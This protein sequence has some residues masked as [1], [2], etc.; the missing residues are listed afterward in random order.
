VFVYVIPSDA[1]SDEEDLPAE[2]PSAQANARLPGTNGDT[3]RA[4][5]LEAP[6]QQGAAAPDGHDSPK[7]ARVS[8]ARLAQLP[9]GGPL[10]PAR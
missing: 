1:V 9:E 10:A 6:S 5:R 7:A 4:R 2:Q 3:R 8:L